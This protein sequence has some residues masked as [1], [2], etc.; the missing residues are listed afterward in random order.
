M[1]PV[2]PDSLEYYKNFGDG[3]DSSD[4]KKGKGKT[5]KGSVGGYLKTQ[6]TNDIGQIRDIGLAGIKVTVEFIDNFRSITLKNINNA[7]VTENNL[8]FNTFFS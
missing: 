6:I 4:T 7:T 1:K 2:P 8:K 5:F 3:F